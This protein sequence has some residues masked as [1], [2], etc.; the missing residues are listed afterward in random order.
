MGTL[1]L[2]GHQPADFLSLT[3]L[4]RLQRL[5]L[6][7]ATLILG[8]Q[9]ILW[10]GAQQPLRGHSQ[11]CLAWPLGL[12]R[13]QATRVGRPASN[14]DWPNALRLSTSK[15]SGSKYGGFKNVDSVEIFGSPR[16]CHLFPCQVTVLDEVSF[17]GGSTCPTAS[18]VNDGV[19][20]LTID[21]FPNLIS[22]GL[23]PQV[24]SKPCTSINL[25]KRAF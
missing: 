4:V 16:F 11:S 21:K 20:L 24:I 10:V 5:E 13:L 19:K 3:D 23:K 18:H 17:V 14:G 15:R 1:K 8:Q 12:G 6:R 7:R 9:E 25:I 22:D 2:K